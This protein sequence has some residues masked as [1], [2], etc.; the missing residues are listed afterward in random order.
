MKLL[1]AGTTFCETWQYNQSPVNSAFHSSGV[2]KLS[3]CLP[4][5]G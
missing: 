3:T 4:G 5:W 2:G 1:Y